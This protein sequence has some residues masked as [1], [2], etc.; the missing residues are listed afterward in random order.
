MEKIP[1]H[2]TR[3]SKCIDIHWIVGGDVAAFVV[4]VGIIIYYYSEYLLL[5]FVKNYIRYT[6]QSRKLVLIF[7]VSRRILYNFCV[8][9]C[10]SNKNLGYTC[11]VRK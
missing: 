7:L 11:Q 10:F 8:R 5:L 6:N 3:A 2:H 1:T 9:D 4:V